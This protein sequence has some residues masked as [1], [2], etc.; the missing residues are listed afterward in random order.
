MLIARESLE[1]KVKEMEE[2]QELM[3]SAHHQGTGRD[4]I[5]S[6]SRLTTEETFTLDGWSRKFA[7]VSVEK[8]LEKYMLVRN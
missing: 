2:T 4:S 7:S 1:L 6:V 5:R 3:L 8:L